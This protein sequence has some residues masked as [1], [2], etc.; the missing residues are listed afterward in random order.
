MTD[1]DDMGVDI[2]CGGPDEPQPNWRRDE[3]P[4]DGI[5]DNDDPTP[6]DTQILIDTLGFDPDEEVY[7]SEPDND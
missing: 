6:I 1:P 3:D 2:Y 4:D 5:D 7:G